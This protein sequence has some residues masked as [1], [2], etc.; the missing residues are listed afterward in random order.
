MMDPAQRTGHDRRATDGGDHGVSVPQRYLALLADVAERLLAAGSAARM[1]DELFT[2][3]RTELRLDV[4]FN[5]RLHDDRLILEAH[6]GLTDAQAADGGE[7]AIGQAICGTVARERRPRH[8]TSLQRSEDPMVAFVKNVGLDAYACTPLVHGDVLLGTLGFGRRWAD[9]FTADELSFLH[10]VCHY[11]AL[12]KYRLR[13]EEELRLAVTSRE[14]LLAELNHRV[15]NALQVAVGL[16][17]M[18]LAAYP[19]PSEGAALKAAADRLQVLAIAHRPLY[20]TG[21]PDTVDVAA[22]LASVVEEASTG[23]S[24]AAVSVARPLPVEAAVAFALLVHTLLDGRADDAPVRLTADIVIDDGGRQR[25]ALL[26]SGCLRDRSQAPTAS[27]R[28][29]RAL[30]HQLRATFDDR[31]SGLMLSLPYALSD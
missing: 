24:L 7:L 12:A 27:Q 20:A 17:A 9:R 31:P 10:T 21:S 25:L 16:V 15:R 26:F 19:D 28:L 30:A 13:V 4:F 6:G 8:A 2:L 23:V 14:R 3:I 5:Y 22:L 29:V 1:V 11:V 18:E